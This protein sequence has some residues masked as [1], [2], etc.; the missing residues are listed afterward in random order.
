M[1][2]YFTNESRDTHKSFTLFVT[3]KVTTKLN[4]GHRNKF[5][6]EFRKIE[7]IEKISRRSSRS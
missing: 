7:K 6:T 3:V 2:L 4:L 5:E 1:T